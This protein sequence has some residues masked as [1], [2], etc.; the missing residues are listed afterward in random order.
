MTTLF[1]KLYLANH[2]SEEEIC[3]MSE[4]N[5]TNKRRVL[6]ASSHALFG[7]GLRSLLK[8]RQ[9]AGVEV[10]G[11]VSN[12]DEAL[13]AIEKLTPDLVI[14]DYD[15]ETLNRDEFLA[16][17]V[18]SEVK[19]R[20]VLLSLQSA[21]EALVYD[22]RS[23]AA[24]QIDDWLE[25]W[26][27]I[28]ETAKSLQ[29]NDDNLNA[30]ANNRRT[31]MK[32][33]VIAGILVVVVTALL[34]AGLEQ[35]RLLPVQASLQAQPIDQLFDLQFKVIAFLFAL[36][37]VLM[38][39]SIVVFRRK[40]GDTTDAAHIEGN[41]NL[42]I[43]WTIAPLA[44][45]LFFAYL[46][47]DSLAET[48]RADPKALEINVIGQ[49]WSWRFEY[50]EYGITTTTMMMPVNK[51]AILHL[52]S[53]DVIHSF[54][55]PEFRVKQDALPGGDDFVRDLRITPS[56]EG[57]YKVRCAEL[58]GLQHS[59]MLAPVMVVS[60]EEFDTWVE[61]ESGGL[62]GDLAAQGQKL[63]ETYG[64]VACHSPDGTELAG[65]TWLGI[66]GNQEMLTD[67]SSVTV[68]DD[69]IRESIL[70]PGNKIVQGFANIMPPN[71]GDQLADEEIAAIIEYIKSLSE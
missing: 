62:E 40:P 8:E 48:L 71:F 61:S 4:T 28:D 47:G 63:A 54:W 25:E 70:N 42:E 36:I 32:H 51:Q 23:M 49:Q 11:M 13:Q 44:T 19:L 22:R 69:Y 41:T 3:H 52:S 50:P 24:A 31:D 10:V 27:Y 16:R 9:G 65:P 1:G 45:V 39:Y 33:L 37:V 38:V 29:T 57:E 68:D 14:V 67:G 12:L 6:I 2:G 21:G 59:T 43:A 46:G 53:T 56:Q 66:Y 58:C 7:E 34:I 35:V 18:E 55:V 15:D 64:C 60:Q 5:L 30:K 20:V 17:F 26:A